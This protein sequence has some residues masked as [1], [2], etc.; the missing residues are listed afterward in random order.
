[1]EIEDKRGFKKYLPIIGVVLLIIVIVVII[2]ILMKGT[3]TESGG[4]PNPESTKSLA[5]NSETFEYPFY[6]YDHS[7]KKTT[8]ITATF[9]NDRLNRIS[10]T[11]TL[12]YPTEAE[13]ITSEAENHAAMN[14][15]FSDAGLGPDSFGANY[16]QL[17]ADTSS[18]SMAMT[19]TTLADSIRDIGAKY[20]ML[21]DVEN[22][23]YTLSDVRTAY[24]NAGFKCEVNN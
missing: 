11:Y 22:K 8:V 6:R 15:S 19:M 13:I 5:C 10:L 1:M 14:I 9:E 21:N 20:F 12:F 3:T 4:Y 2:I 7:T 17:L 18:L 16:R 23:D 24:R